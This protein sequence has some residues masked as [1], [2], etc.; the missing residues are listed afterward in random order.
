MSPDIEDVNGFL[1][2]AFVYLAFV[3]VWLG[4]RK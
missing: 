2:M 4:Y 1:T 3:L